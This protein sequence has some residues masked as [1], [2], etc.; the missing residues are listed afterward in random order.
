MAACPVD[1]IT[2][3]FGTAKRGVDIPHVRE[4]FE[5]NIDG[6]YIAGE[7]GGMGLIRNAVTQGKQAM[8][9]IASRSKNRDA[10]VHD[11]VVV[12]AGPAGLSA[13]L[14][15]EKSGLRFV[16]VDQGDIGGTVL[17]YPRQKLVMTQPMEIPVYGKYSKRT[18]Q[19]EELLDLWR[20]VI[21]RTG[22]E[23]RTEER[24]VE[25]VRPN[26]YFEVTTT[27]DRYTTRNVLLAIG[28]RGTP[29]KLDVPGE[30]ASKVTYQLLDPGQYQNKKLL[31]IGGGDSAV[32]AAL[33]LADENGAEVTLSYRNEA[34]SR[35]KED[36]LERINHAIETG[37]VNMLF[38]SRVTRITGTSVT[39]NH[40]EEELDIPNDFVFV[41]IGGELPTPL[42]ERIGIQIETKFGE[43]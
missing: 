22:V 16:T 12:G 20:D 21:D 24:L 31:V 5:T 6:V 26:G 13:T 23:I 25:I 14:Q 27:R 39:L 37:A 40:R 33:A 4:N 10:S 1:A 36:N 9:D 7:L 41:L 29:R 28:R 38:E 18:I 32:E 3:V 35:V 17:T 15:A 2:L 30:N 19:K 8:D 34:F 42:L 43:R 11:V